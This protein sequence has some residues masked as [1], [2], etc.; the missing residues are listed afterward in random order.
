MGCA[1]HSRGDLL[2][3]GK[4]IN[5][6]PLFRLRNSLSDQADPYEFKFLPTEVRSHDQISR[7]IILDAS[8]QVF[9]EYFLSSSG[10]FVRIPD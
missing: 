5:D 7:L 3:S 4:E 9:G 10:E 1:L 6:A 2:S 8:Y